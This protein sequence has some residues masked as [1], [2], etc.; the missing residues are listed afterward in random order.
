[1]YGAGRLHGIWAASMEDVETTHLAKHLLPGVDQVIA[2]ALTA[3]Y[4]AAAPQ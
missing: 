2:Q 1:M 3:A 4:P